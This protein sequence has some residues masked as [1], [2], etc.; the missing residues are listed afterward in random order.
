MKLRESVA[1]GMVSFVVGL[2]VVI[3]C[4]KPTSDT[5]VRPSTRSED[6][7]VNQQEQAE[8]KEVEGTATFGNQ[9][10]FGTTIPPQPVP[11]TLQK[12]P[13]PLKKVQLAE[14]LQAYVLQADCRKK[15]LD[16]RNPNR[17]FEP[18]TWELMPDGNFVF[19][20]S[21]GV[22]R[23]KDDG[24][25][26]FN[27][28]IPMTVEMW[29]QVDCSDRDKP[30]IRVES[31]W[32]LGKKFED[33]N[34]PGSNPSPTPSGSPRPSPSPSGSPTP[35]P[36][37]TVTPRPTP[38][39]TLRPILPRPRPTSGVEAVNVEPRNILLS[40]FA[41]TG[42]SDNSPTCK[43]PSGCYFHNILRFDQCS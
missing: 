42:S 21:G 32:W 7:S 41:E 24:L 28:T 40:P 16:V 26:D 30:V 10:P 39:S 43:L 17:A 18:V 5:V 23:L 9:C 22:A 4:G 38:T 1:K 19:T 11:L 25:G 14:P 15:T 2:G 34:T 3:G 37:P 33:A 35:S 29:G 13:M 6:P 12:C 31:V 8:T 36:S 27:C 20:M